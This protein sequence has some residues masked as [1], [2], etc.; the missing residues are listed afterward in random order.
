MMKSLDSLWQGLCLRMARLSGARFCLLLL[1]M[2]LTPLLLP[3]ALGWLLQNPAREAGEEN[4]RRQQALAQVKAQ[5]RRL[6]AELERLRQEIS[7]P[8]SAVPDCRS[9]PEWLVSGQ[10]KAWRQESQKPLRWSASLS[11][12]YPELL[13]LLGRLEPCPL[14]IQSLRITRSEQGVDAEIHLGEEA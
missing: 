4:A 12:A 3:A 10:V 8:Q 14:L 7:I 2:A 13:A 9:L 6:M 1:G 11:L 5:N